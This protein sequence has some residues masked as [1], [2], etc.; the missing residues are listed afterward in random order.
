MSVHTFYGWIH[1][2]VDWRT[3]KKFPLI[4]SQESIKLLHNVKDQYKT[5]HVSYGM[6]GNDTI[7]YVNCSVPVIRKMNKGIVEY[8]G[9][10]NSVNG[11]ELTV[12][13]K[14]QKYNIKERSG[15]KFTL[16]SIDTRYE[17]VQS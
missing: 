16:E 2:Q 15:L 14:P 8:I 12:K 7:M 11:V 6:N 9:E 13:I 4:L 1:E 3:D 17:Q 10:K 5:H